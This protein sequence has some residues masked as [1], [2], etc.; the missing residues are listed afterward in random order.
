MSKS[1]PAKKIKKNG[2]QKLYGYIINALILTT[3]ILIFYFVAMLQVDLSPEA[4]QTLKDG[5]KASTGAL[6]GIR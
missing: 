1:K 4:Q 6:R 2:K 3:F 5:D